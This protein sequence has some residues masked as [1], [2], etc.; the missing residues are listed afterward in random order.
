MKKYKFN[1][2]VAEPYDCMR[3]R[4]VIGTTAT[5]MWEENDP[6]G[7]M[8]RMQKWMERSSKLRVNKSLDE[9]HRIKMV[10]ETA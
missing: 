8:D 1:V 9:W 4:E 10:E 3:M 7:A 6:Q 2:Y 5:L